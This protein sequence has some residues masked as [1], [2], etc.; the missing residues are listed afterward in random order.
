MSQKE[1]MVRKLTMEKPKALLEKGVVENIITME[2]IVEVTHFQ[3]ENFLKWLC[4]P[5][6]SSISD[7]AA[8]LESFCKD[9]NKATAEVLKEITNG[10]EKQDEPE[11]V[12]PESETQAKGHKG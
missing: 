12:K 7:T 3:F 9:V 8:M 1:R 10:E 4:L 5:N 6:S 11:K 2:K